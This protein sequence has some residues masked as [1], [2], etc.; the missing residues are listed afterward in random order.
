MLG[1]NPKAEGARQKILILYNDFSE[2]KYEILL[3]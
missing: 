1:R 3:L 2:T